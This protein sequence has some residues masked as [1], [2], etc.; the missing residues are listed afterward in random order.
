MEQIHKSQA[1]EDRKKLLVDQAEARK[2]KIKEAQKRV[3]GVPISQKGGDNQNSVQ[4]RR[5]Q[6]IKLPS[7]LCT[8]TSLFTHMIS[9]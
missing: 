4:G 7:H 1:E 5:D 9:H 2:S 3:G 6:E 8:V